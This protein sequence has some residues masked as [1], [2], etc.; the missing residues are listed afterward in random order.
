MIPSFFGTSDSR[1]FGIYHPPR[2]ARPRDVGVL[3]CYPAPQEYMRTHWAF[4]K[5]AAMLA[6]DG[7]HVF[8]FDYFGTGDSGGESAEVSLHLWRTNVLTATRE[9]RDVASVSK[10]S[11]VGFRLGAAI[12]ATADQAFSDLVLWEPVVQGA[13]YLAELEAVQH[14]SVALDLHSPWRDPNRP[15]ELLG[16]P[17]HPGIEREIRA[18]DLTSLPPPRAARVAIMVSDDRPSF[19]TLERHLQAKN[20]SVTFRHVPD[21]TA[22]RSEGQQA[23]LLSNTMLEA[24]TA[25]LAGR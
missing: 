18:M 12:A 17:F 11:A 16:F 7:F 8:R 20:I 2:S 13:S 19:R 22:A 23:A 6:K 15:P 14:R 4:R 10:V 5:L 9:L 21:E 24:I 25:H 3:L 1:L